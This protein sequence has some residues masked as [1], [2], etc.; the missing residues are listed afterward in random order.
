[1]SSANHMSEGSEKSSHCAFFCC[2]LQMPDRIQQYGRVKFAFDNFSDE[3]VRCRRS[4][5]HRAIHT[6]ETVT[7]EDVCAFIPP[8]LWS[9]GSDASG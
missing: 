7:A 4:L 3:D 9:R 2:V 1:M 5:F 6:S 8:P